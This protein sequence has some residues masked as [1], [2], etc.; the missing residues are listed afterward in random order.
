[1]ANAILK[2]QQAGGK[3]AIQVTLVT[4]LV[5][6]CLLLT[7]LLSSTGSLTYLDEIL[8]SISLPT[9]IVF[10]FSTLLF[11]YLLGRKLAVDILMEGKKSYWKCYTTAISVVLLSIGVASAFALI[12]QAIG[13]S[14]P[15]NWLILYVAKPIIWMVPISIV[16]ILIAGTW[17][18]NQ[19][20]KIKQ[21]S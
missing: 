4:E 5:A 13:H 3:F 2:T 15:E 20:K 8:G 16:P 9:V 11:S 10:V 14:L 17:Y 1:M 12:N 21:C 6:L 7:F 19:L 18:K